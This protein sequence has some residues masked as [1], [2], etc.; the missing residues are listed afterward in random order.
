MRLSNGRFFP[1]PILLGISKLEK[2]R[3]IKYS[4]I[5]LLYIKKNWIFGK[6]QNFSINKK[7]Y[8]NDIYVGMIKITL[9]LTFFL[10]NKNFLVMVKIDKKISIN[11]LF[12]I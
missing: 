3:I 5:K 9:E 1:I 11:I 7:K 10:K 4:K 6:F 8:L 12:Q 2:E